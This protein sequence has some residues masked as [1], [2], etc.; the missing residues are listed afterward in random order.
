VAARDVNGDGTTDVLVGAVFADNNGRQG[1]GSVY[2]V[3][4]SGSRSAIVDLAALGGQGLRIDGATAFDFAGGSVAAPG[5]VNGDTG[6]DILLGAAGSDNNGRQDSGS[7]YVV[8]LTGWGPS[9]DLGALGDRGFRI[10]GAGANDSAGGHVAGAGDFNGD[11]R[12]D[13]LIGARG[14]AGGGAQSSGAVYVLYGFGRSEL[15]YDPL[16]ATVGRRIK[17]HSPRIVRRTGQPRF[18]VSRPLP[19]GLELDP[20]TGVVTGTP[21]VYERRTTYTVTMS[22][23][24]SSVRAPL[25]IAVTDTSAPKLRLGGPAV[26][27]VLRQ[28][29][30]TV[31]AS[32]NEPCRLS[33]RGTITVPGLGT[34]TLRRARAS[35]GAAGTRRLSLALSAAAQHRLA[36]WLVRGRR[37]RATVAVH[38]AD[39]A[40]NASTATRT[41]ALKT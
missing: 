33:A 20:G 24:A 6:A 26:Q 34:V 4:G 23:L 37:G 10:D 16:A 11:E 22:D 29:A 14:V 12:P 17:P 3:F 38:A 32:C 30:V 21:A 36:G 35:L 28:N 19:A 7:A 27:S 15:A 41:I 18:S 1:S 9:L 13:V 39:R 25:S 31:R 8:Y 2:V 40:G 5:D